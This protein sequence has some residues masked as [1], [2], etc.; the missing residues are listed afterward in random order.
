MLFP[1]EHRVVPSP[2]YDQCL[3]VVDLRP[4]KRKDLS[5]PPG[6]M[7]EYA[8]PHNM[9]SSF[10]ATAFD[11][12]AMEKVWHHPSQFVTP[13][14]SILESTQSSAPLEA[15]FSDEDLDALEA[16]VRFLKF[17]RQAWQDIGGD[18]PDPKTSLGSDQSMTNRRAQF[19]LGGQ[20]NSAETM[21]G[22]AN[23]DAH[24]HGPCGQM[25]P[26]PLGFTVVDRRPQPGQPPLW[27]IFVDNS[28][29]VPTSRLCNGSRSPIK[30]TS[31]GK[32]L[33]TSRTSSERDQSYQTFKPISPQ[34][35]SENIPS[36]G[37]LQRGGMLMFSV[38]QNNAIR[39]TRQD[40][41]PRGPLA[42]NISSMQPFQNSQLFSTRQSLHFR[43]F[44]P[45]KDL[46]K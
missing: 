6:I 42:Y 9:V 23:P 45:E 28:E 29:P 35:L 13:A 30:Q 25:L 21:L 44:D 26:L 16:A 15:L 40:S 33:L 24:L 37:Q 34:T 3:S 10:P 32:K 43:R 12:Y 8:V 5:T 20:Q 36:P 31:P 1:D 17:C 19:D 46:E 2:K 14:G 41:L 22:R 38:K 18:F 39:K 7:H 11:L 27:G 4:R